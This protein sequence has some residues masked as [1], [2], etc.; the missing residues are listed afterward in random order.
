MATYRYP[1]D[2]QSPIAGALSNLVS[3]I[4][5]MPGPE[6]RA[7]KQAQLQQIQAN[8][9]LARSKIADSQREAAFGG[10]LAGVFRKAL[11]PVEEARPTP[12]SVGPMPEVPAD[13]R[14]AK[15]LPDLAGSL[16]PAQIG[17][18]GGLMLALTANAPGTTDQAV[19]RAGLGD[20]VA[21]NSTPIGAGQERDRKIEQ[22]DRKDVRAQNSAKYAADRAATAQEAIAARAE[23]AAANRPQLF[24][25]PNSPTGISIWAP[26]S[27]AHMKPGVPPQA[28]TSLQTGAAKQLDA[29]QIFDQNLTDFQNLAAQNQNSMGIAGDTARV[30][31]GV[32]S[33]A[34]ALASNFGINLQP[35]IDKAK[36]QLAQAGIQVPDATAASQLD[37][38]GKLV[39]RLAAKAFGES[40][41][42]GFS[43]QDAARYAAAFG[44]SPIANLQDLNARAS[45]VRKMLAN[46]I[47]VMGARAGNSAPKGLGTT[48]TAPMAAPATPGAGPTSAPAVVP[49]QSKVQKWGRDSTGRPIPLGP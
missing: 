21:Y 27:G 45:V 44:E 36:A 33:Q 24:A 31:S 26:G 39:P 12:D 2:F 42:A 35:V 23:T 32:T 41:G 25:D 8:T 15:A 13:V 40:T 3:S 38:Y 9:D 6:E 19:T 22:E 17:Q 16:P 49:S 34:G 48:V 43:N 37:T 47:A 5:S 46:D 11:T 4:A 30:L 14:I 18:L 29:L 1:N 7:L 10:N 28:A 20:K